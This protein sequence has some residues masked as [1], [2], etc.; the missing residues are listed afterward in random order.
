MKGEVE[1]AKNNEVSETKILKEISLLRSP[2]SLTLWPRKATGDTGPNN[3]T[4]ERERNV[5]S[6][7]SA[8]GSCG[9]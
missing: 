7:V 4:G 9:G 8:T 6:V 3:N 1:R 2:K 5:V